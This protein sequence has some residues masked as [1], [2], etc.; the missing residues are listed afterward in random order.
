[1][2]PSILI[3]GATQGVGR[4]VIERLTGDPVLHQG[5]VHAISRH[6]C[7]APSASHAAIQWH[8]CD[9]SGEVTLPS[10]TFWVSA[11]PINLLLRGLQHSSAQQPKAIWALSS[12]S[13]EFKAE[14]ASAKER[15]QMQ[16]IVSCERALVQHCQRQDIRLQLFKTT[17]LY[18]RGDHN[19]NRLDQLIR[20]LR[21][22]PIVGAGRRA[23]V[24]VDDVAA[25]MVADLVRV[26]QGQP[27]ASGTWYLQGDEILSYPSMIERIARFRGH[28]CWSVRIPLRPLQTA[29]QL[30]HAVGLL[31]DIDLTMLSRQSMDLLVD[32]QPART[33]LGWAPRR[34]EPYPDKG[35]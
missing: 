25:L 27:K 15:A 35:L 12:A 31:A 11:G 5:Q 29:L 22:I 2:D 34:F 3:L 13:T 21:V 28:R 8:R 20:R 18:G 16:S 33:Q 23:P 4:S 1:M 30:A 7:P 6:K 26:C 19:V 9:L 24:H 32:D 10:A 17:L 14:S